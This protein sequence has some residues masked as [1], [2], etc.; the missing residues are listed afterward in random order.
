MRRNMHVLLVVIAAAVSVAVTMPHDLFAQ[1]IKERMKNRLPKI[2]DMK[3]KGIIGENNRGYLAY[4]S[5]RKPNREVVENENRDRRKIYAYIADKQGTTLE[6]VE[7]LRAEQIAENAEPGDYLQK[8]DGT[9]YR[10]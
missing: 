9:W 10:K 1:G 5:D 7:K 8:P 3:E 4:V 2:V 6:K